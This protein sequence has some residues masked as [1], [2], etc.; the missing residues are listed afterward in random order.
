MSFLN[1]F[2]RKGAQWTFAGYTAEFPDV[3]DDAGNL[4]KHRLCNAKSIPGCKAFHIPKEDPSLSKEVEIG[5]D[6]LGQPLED[7]VLVFQYKGKFHAVDH[8]CPHSQFPLSRGTPFDIED[9]GVTLSVGVT[10]PKHD[11]SF[12]LFTG[13]SDRGSYKLKTWEVQIRDTREQD[14]SQADGEMEKPSNK[15][16]WVRRKQRIG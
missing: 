9:F 12:D 5:D 16:I 15:G 13:M 7:Q 6:A 10:C 1:P 14:S 4:A 8:S 11:W 3:D 2:S